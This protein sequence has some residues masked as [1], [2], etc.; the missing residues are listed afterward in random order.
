MMLKGK[1]ALVTGAVAG[2]GYAIAESLAE[3]GANVVLNALSDPGTGET[4]ASKL[5][6]T[7]NVTAV[8]DGA[9]L[10]DVHA[11][12][13]MIAS[14]QQRF[15]GVDILVNNAVV[16]HFKRAEDFTAA[17]WDTSIAV[18]LSAAFHCAR[19]TIPSMRARRWG[20]IINI[21]SIYGSRAAENRI[22]YVTTKTALIGMARAIGI[23]TAQT[24]ITCNAV[25]PGTVKSPAI[26]QRI[27]ALAAE[28]KIPLEQ[29]E[30]DYITVR[31]PTGRFVDLKSVGAMV[32]FLCSPA[33]A[34]I[35]GT[36]LPIDGGWH[37]S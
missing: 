1:C 22:D 37:V 23:E 31:H 10:R 28:Q 29:A 21:A 13:R 35:T 6:K 27:A 5:T 18:N 30:H 16:R 15:G 11:I 19:L 17:E 8:F 12:E 20:R 36:A 25:C 33:G 7:H 4:A 14:A 2:L 32:L 3:A 24:G 34:D 9:D 26:V